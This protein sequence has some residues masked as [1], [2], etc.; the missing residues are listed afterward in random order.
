[1]L[2]KNFQINNEHGLHARPASLLSETARLYDS[3][4]KI[5][6][7]GM[8]ADAKS[9]LTILLLEVSPGS[10]V[11]IVAEG[12]DEK[13]AMNAIDGLIAGNFDE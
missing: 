2:V 3:E 1:M 10:T 12:A 9:I 8:E 5:L 7:N 11:T 13:D 6:F 4:I